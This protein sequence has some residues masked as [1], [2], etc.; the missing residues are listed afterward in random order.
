MANFLIVFL[1]I[2]ALAM[3]LNLVVKGVFWASRRFGEWFF[4]TALATCL[5]LLAAFH[6]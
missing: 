1:S 2:M 6:E 3:F 4:I 5:G